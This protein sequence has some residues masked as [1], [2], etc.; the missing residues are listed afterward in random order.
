MG[1]PR[2]H[3]AHRLHAR[4]S[5]RFH[6]P[7]RQERS[8]VS[9]VYDRLWATITSGRPF[10]ARVVNRRKDGSHHVA[11]V[12]IDPVQRGDS[13]V[14]GFIG[15][16]KDV[17]DDEQRRQ[18]LRERET[19]AL[20]R[21]RDLVRDRSL[22]VQLLSHELRT[23]LTILVGSARTLERAHLDAQVRG[24]L[25]D[26]LSRATDDV[27][28]RLDALMSA[29][30]DLGGRVEMVALD[31]LIRSLTG[32]LAPRFDAARVRT[33]GA[34]NWTGDAILIQAVLRPIVE[35]ALKFSPSDSPVHIRLSAGGSGALTPSS[36]RPVGPAVAADGD[37]RQWPTP[38]GGAGPRESSTASSTGVAS[39]AR[40][41][42]SSS[43]ARSRSS[44]VAQ[45]G[46]SG[47]NS[48]PW[49]ERATRAR[50]GAGSGRSPR[51]RAAMSSAHARSSSP[52]RPSDA[53]VIT[54]V[55]RD[56]SAASS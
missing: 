51:S 9:V 12:T 6:A 15:V 23:P 56:G 21:E 5:H 47:A 13:E 40:S 30:D 4:G 53:P 3:R 50:N 11:Q 27:L 10:A 16:Q 1:E 28:E 33:E 34:A 19:A 49:S 38:G 29:T 22:L 18:R 39:T 20:E 41:K 36:M 7:D 31:E 8:A 46:P 32:S 44:R 54:N 14:V 24:Q 26:A 25:L 37:H 43:S 45:V 2:V 48:R 35:N 42:R 52:S 55:T 17:T